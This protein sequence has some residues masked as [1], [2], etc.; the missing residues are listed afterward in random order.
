VEVTFGFVPGPVL[1]LP[2]LGRWRRRRG[3]SRPTPVSAHRSRMGLGPP[4]SPH[5]KRGRDPRGR[6]SHHRRGQNRGGGNITPPV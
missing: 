6:D 3:G 2:R 1:A 4:P 5:R